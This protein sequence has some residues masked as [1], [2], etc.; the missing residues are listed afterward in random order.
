MELYCTP[1]RSKLHSVIIEGKWGQVKT[2]FWGVHWTDG[3]HLARM[4]YADDCIPILD[5]KGFVNAGK[6]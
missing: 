6:D 1:K 5:E 2:R 3:E 4:V